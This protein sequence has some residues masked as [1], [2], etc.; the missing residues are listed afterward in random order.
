ME[1]TLDEKGF[2]VLKKSLTPVQ[3]HEIKLQLTI[4]PYQFGFENPQVDSSFQVYKEDD[5]YIYLPRY[6]AFKYFS[7]PVSTFYPRL[8]EQQDIWNFHGILRPQQ[9]FIVNKIKPMITNEGGGILSCVCGF[10]KTCMA[11][12][13]A[14]QLKVKTLIVV[15]KTQLLNQWRKALEHFTPGIQVGLIQQD[16][17]DTCQR[18]ITLSMLQ[19]LSSKDYDESVLHE[20]EFIIIDEVHN[21]ATKT[22]SKTLLKITP[23]YTLGLSATPQRPDGTSKVF[24]W[25]LGPFL[26]KVTAKDSVKETLM[27]VNII[28]YHDTDR[29][30]REIINKDGR[31][32]LPV[33]LSNMAVLPKRNNMLVQVLY[34]VVSLPSRYILVLGSRIKQL[35]ELKTALDKR[36]NSEV[37]TSM[38]I[39][40]MKKQELERALLDASVLFATYEMAN[41]GFDH[42]KLNTLVFVTPRSRV[43]QAT[44]RILRKLDPDNPPLV[45]D[46]IDQLPVYQKQGEKRISFYKSLNYNIQELTV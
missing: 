1:W 31:R 8:Y 5:V 15:N 24:H 4:Q 34:R 7:L 39:G 12:Y 6:W 13:L 21:I 27:T 43:E 44:G 42:P 3:I 36:T 46:I 22:F 32:C 11:I 17:V 2:C 30:F 23:A 25:Y 19:S 35:E 45:Y 40:S 16:K 14:T 10:G 29:R 9:E 18:P 26:H 41:E 20:F 38:F 28:R 33:M 37:K